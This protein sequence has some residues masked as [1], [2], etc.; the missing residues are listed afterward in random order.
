MNLSHNLRTSCTYEFSN[1]DAA[2]A[3]MKEVVVI[4]RF[5]VSQ[6]FLKLQWQSPRRTFLKV[7]DTLVPRS[8]I[9]VPFSATIVSLWRGQMPCF[10]AY[11][12]SPVMI[13]NDLAGKNTSIFWVSFLKF[14]THAEPND[15]DSIVSSKTLCV[16][17]CGGIPI[18]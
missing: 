6:Y 3:S 7:K 13:N 14:M 11:L 1:P 4:L 16:S 10:H 18:I 2:S 8:C 17:M 15:R 9:V 12:A 5:A